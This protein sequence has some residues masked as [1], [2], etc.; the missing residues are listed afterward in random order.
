[1]SD[2]KDTPSAEPE[3]I[4]TVFDVICGS[5][6]QLTNDLI[7]KLLTL[8]DASIPNER[9]AKAFKDVLRNIVWK[10][11]DHRI[12]SLRSDLYYCE[13]QGSPMLE[14]SQRKYLELEA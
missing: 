13:K 12:A 4:R 6:L 7:G 5:N 8:V 11:E 9:Q 14:D 2:R 1:M 3:P 10:R